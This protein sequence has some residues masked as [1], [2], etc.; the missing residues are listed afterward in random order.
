MKKLLTISLCLVVALSAC[1]PTFGQ[2]TEAIDPNAAVQTAVAGTKAVENAVG[3]SVAL[4]AAAQQDQGGGGG[5][6]SNP[7]P[8]ATTEPPPPPP[9]ENPAPT[10]TAKSNANCRSGPAGTF[11][12]ILIMKAGES[13][14]IIGKNTS[15]ISP[16]YKLELADGKQCWVS[17][18]ALEISGDVA[19]VIEMASPPTPTPR[20]VWAGTWTIWWRGGFTG[21]TDANTTMKCTETG[22]TVVCNLSSWDF[23]F[24]LTGTKSADNQYLTGKLTRNVG[25]GP[26]DVRLIKLGDNQFAGAWWYAPYGAEWDGDWCGA[27]EGAPKPDPC[28]R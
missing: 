3:T 8:A 12:Y 9:T 4:T 20:P 28:K 25:G 7:P 18:D 27:R 24:V 22:S 11:E 26:W 19:G 13:G 14:K 1:I 23:S 5:G 2:Q 6:G 15:G 10:G 16:W 17:S 21:A